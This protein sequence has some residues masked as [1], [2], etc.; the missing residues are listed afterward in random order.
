MTN[1]DAVLSAEYRAFVRSLHKE[2]IETVI[3]VESWWKLHAFR[4][5]IRGGF[6][7]GREDGP[8]SEAEADKLENQWR[9]EIRPP[10]MSLIY[11]HPDPDVRDAADFLDKR[12]LS[13]IIII[14]DP[15]A[16]RRS[17]EDENSVAIHLVHDGMQRLIRAAYHA[18]FRVERP[19]PRF[20][21][22]QIGNTEP[23]P[24]RMLELIR[25]LQDAGAL[26]PD[27]DRFLGSRI[28]EAVKRLSDIFFMPE[29]ERVALF[30]R[31][32]VETPA[33]SEPDLESLPQ[34]FGFSF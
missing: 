1:T 16:E 28:P 3:A 2:T 18:P 12:L 29:D 17:R 8:D 4:A 27:E 19:E 20:E 5:A 13:I 11:G 26:E 25:Q 22:H 14:T 9:H 15:R 10:L 31:F 33:A 21:G 7:T 24:G 32:N 30:E 6:D 23:L 34:G